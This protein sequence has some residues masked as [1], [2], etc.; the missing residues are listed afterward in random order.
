[1][2]WIP[3]NAQVYNNFDEYEDQKVFAI[4][5]DGTVLVGNLFKSTQHNNRINCEDD[6]VFI[7][8]VQYIIPVTQV[9]EEL[10]KLL[11]KQ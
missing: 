1:M 3:V 5:K 9:V 4:D 6:N 7:T 2:K 11:L 10:R 8:D